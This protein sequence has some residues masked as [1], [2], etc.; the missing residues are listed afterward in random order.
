MKYTTAALCV[1][2]AT[3]SLA[4]PAPQAPPTPAGYA[5][6]SVLKVH[7]INTNLNTAATASSTVRNGNVETST[8]YQ[9]PIPAAAAGLT[10]AF[11][12][13]AS[14]TDTV[15]GTQTMDIFSNTFTDLATLTSGNLRDQPLGRVVYNPT[16]GY[17]DFNSADVTPRVVAFPCPAAGTSL[18][19]ETVAVGDF[20]VN[21]V[22]QDFTPPAG[23]PPN[24]IS[25]AYY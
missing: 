1:L 17:Y 21:N 23:A 18:Y 14:A 19:W 20:D 5:V 2:S 16:T 6:P 3:L 25:V 7:S 10:C 24:G 12:F 11:V 13:T 15:Q 4:A 8:L 22:R 9:I